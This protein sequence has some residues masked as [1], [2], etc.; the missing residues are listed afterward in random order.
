M[1][2]NSI[3]FWNYVGQS[4]LFWLFLVKFC[5]VNIAGFFKYIWPFFKTTNKKVNLNISFLSWVN[6]DKTIYIMKKN[7]LM[8]AKKVDRLIFEKIKSRNSKNQSSKSLAIV[9][10]N[11]LLNRKNIQIKE[12]ILLLWA[13]VVI[14]LLLGQ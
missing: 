12:N 13:I 2:T 3:L 1:L 8:H 6:A 7:W 5:D 9:L 14:L 11:N 10:E 4:Y